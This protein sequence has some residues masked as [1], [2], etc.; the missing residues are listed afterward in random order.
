MELNG[1]LWDNYCP[2]L[3]L[4]PHLNIS[5]SLRLP[6]SPM[7]W[8]SSVHYFLIKALFIIMVVPAGASSCR[9]NNSFLKRWEGRQGCSKEP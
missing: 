1:L 9:L 6:A 2:Y 7:N 3:Q 5:E 8:G 4:A